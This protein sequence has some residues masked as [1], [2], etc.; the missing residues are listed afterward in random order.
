LT[1]HINKTGQYT[2]V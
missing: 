1:K 2:E